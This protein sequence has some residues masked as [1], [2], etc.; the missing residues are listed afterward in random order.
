MDFAGDFGVDF[1]DDELSE[2]EL[3][4]EELPVADSDVDPSEVD[5]DSEESFDGLL[6][7]EAD[8]DSVLESAR[9]SFR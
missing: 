7:A 8:S 9:L 2:V 4:D 1:L 3:S 5:F 6:F